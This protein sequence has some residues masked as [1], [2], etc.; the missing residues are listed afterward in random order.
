MAKVVVESK[1]RWGEL[2]DEASR[3]VLVHLRDPNPER[4]PTVKVATTV[5]SSYTRHEQT[6]SAREAT[7]VLIARELAE[8][9]AEFQQYLKISLPRLQLPKGKG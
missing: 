1:E 4:I 6:E 7:A 2:F 5:L 9:K 8:N 3:V